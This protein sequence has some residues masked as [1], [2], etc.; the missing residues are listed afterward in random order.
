M[1][2]VS[3]Q[4]QDQA[5]DRVAGPCGQVRSVSCQQ[6]DQAGERGAG[7]CG[8][9][10][11]VSCQQQD[12]AGERAAGPRGSQKNHAEGHQASCC[13]RGAG[14][15]Q[16]GCRQQQA[17]CSLSPVGNKGAGG[18]MVSRVCVLGVGGGGGVHGKNR[19]V[20]VSSKEVVLKS[21]VENS[22]AGKIGRLSS[23]AGE[24]SSDSDGE[25]GGRGKYGE[26]GGEQGGRRELCWSSSG[27]GEAGEGMAGEAGGSKS[28][29][30]PLLGGAGAR[31]GTCCRLRCCCTDL[32]P[33]KNQG[34]AT[35][36]W[37]QSPTPAW[38]AWHEQVRWRVK[39][40]NL[41]AHL[42]KWNGLVP[43]TVFTSLSFLFLFMSPS[44]TQKNVC[45]KCWQPSVGSCLV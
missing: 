5:G 39:K 13:K 7:P 42:I 8:Q 22:R 6:Q 17:S 4:Q 19:P 32:D 30:L 37:G 44:A 34:L 25:Q 31:Q 41:S 26:P 10:K 38:H 23:A 16:V 12:Q 24:L 20:V 36:E 21:Q 35:A 3:C 33:W 2:L 40:L 29:S 28:L 14:V 45:R 27:A 18:S 9:V 15:G 11:L 43:A 1:R